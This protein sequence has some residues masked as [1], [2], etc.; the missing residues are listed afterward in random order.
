VTHVLVE[1]KSGRLG[2]ECR[3]V[4]DCTGDAD[5]CERSGEVT[6]SLDSNVPSGWY[7]R[8]EDGRPRL[9]QLSNW[10]CREGG[11]ERA[12]GPFFRGDVGSDVSAQ[13]IHTRDMV[14]QEVAQFRSEHAETLCLPFQLS[15]LPSF[16]MTRRLVGRYSLCKADRHRWLGDAIGLTGDWRERGP[17]YAIPY[18][19]I[20]GTRNTNLFVAGRCI[21]ADRTIWDATRA[22]PTCALTGE[23]S[24]TAAAMCCRSGVDSSSISVHGLQNRLRAKGCLIDPGLVHPAL[25]R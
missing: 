25:E 4:I 13:V 19:A 6:E 11:K 9:R 12:K 7:Y 22:I 18:D 21:S 20:R 8:M 14:R 16:R 15:L 24:G 2:I 10:H 23:A 3:A 1:N 17:V 5:V